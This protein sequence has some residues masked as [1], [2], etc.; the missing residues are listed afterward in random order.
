MILKLY[1]N[2]QETFHNYAWRTLQIC[3][4]DGIG[5]LIFIVA[6]K[7]LQ[8]LVFGTYNYL[9]A[10]MSLFVVFANFGV[11]AAA[12]KFVAEFGVGDSAKEHLVAFN[13]ALLVM[14]L[15]LV[16]MVLV[17]ISSRF[18]KIDFVLLLVLLP[19][20]FLVPLAALLDGIYQGRKR[21]KSLALISLLTGLVSLGIVWL[22]IRWLGLA[23]ALLAHNIYYLLLLAG[24][25]AGYRK[26]FRQVDFAL[27]R[28]IGGYAA[29]I[30][31]SSL[32]HFLYTKAD[33]LVLG[34]F[35]YL[36]E[37]GHYEIINKVMTLVVIPVTILATVMAPNSA[38]RMARR[39]YSAIR[40][41]LLRETPIILLLGVVA[42]A[43]LY[44]LLPRAME[45]FL[46]NYDLALMKQLLSVLV[47]VL[48]LIFVSTYT[49]TG[50]IV[51]TGAARTT[52]GYLMVCGGA[53]VVLDFIL[54]SAFGFIGVAYATLI[55]KTAFVAFRNLAFYRLAWSW[56]QVDHTL[57]EGT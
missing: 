38:R 39:D 10:F 2:H 56:G 15:G 41:K 11:S 4:R 42:A 44:L 13:A 18:M 34:H 55:T 35:G 57:E 7:Q 1:H 36:R 47:F 43:L 48:P 52:M 26:M 30:G 53:N 21:F 51:P 27:M 46:P 45:I 14:G 50:H 17:I 54:I 24:L 22:L 20:I 5:L 6:A 29:V 31:L 40:R 3:A 16:V 32:G 19:M 33:L 12:S 49:N 25:I 37:V 28:R 8:P 23:G 9:I